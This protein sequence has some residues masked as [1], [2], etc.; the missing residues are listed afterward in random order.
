MGPEIGLAASAREWSD[1]FHRFLLDHGG[2]TVRS[3]VMSPAQA[4]ASQFDVLFIDDVCSFLNQRLVIDVRASGK[5]IVGVF[6]PSDGTDAKRRLLEAGIGDVIESDARAEE[7]LEIAAVTISHSVPPSQVTFESDGGGFQIGLTG[8]PGGVGVTE[9]AY[10]LALDLSRR[11]KTALVDANPDWPSIGQRLGLP[12]HP[13]LRTGIDFVLHEPDRLEEAAHLVGALSVI[14]GPANPG[15]VTVSP[16]DLVALISAL[17]RAHSH[18]V[19]DLGHLP[20][21]CAD[22]LRCFDAILVVGTGDPVGVTRLARTANRVATSLAP[23]C[24]MGLVV[25]RVERGARERREIVSVLAGCIPGIPVVLIPED[26]GIRRAAWD[27]SSVGKGPFSRSVRR[28]GRIFDVV[29][30]R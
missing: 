9:V 26:R 17:G 21:L 6:D 24:E 3:R 30:P 22:L 8:P 27:G 7:F 18:V 13:N 15:V 2:G 29:R 16:A 10:A 5:S 14:P 4:V 20:D 1:R 11:H 25:N 23:D 12:V 19:V 28:L